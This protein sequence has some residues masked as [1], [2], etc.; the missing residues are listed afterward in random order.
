M[1]RTDPD[2]DGSVGKADAETHDEE[3]QSALELLVLRAF[4]DGEE[5]EGVWDI[6]YDHEDLPDWTVTVDRKDRI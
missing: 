2:I 5:V 6:E 4:A 3:F 1:R